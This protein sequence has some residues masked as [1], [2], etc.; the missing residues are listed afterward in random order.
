MSP[1]RSSMI[2]PDEIKPSVLDFPTQPETSF[3]AQRQPFPSKKADRDFLG[4]WTAEGSDVYARVS[5]LKNSEHAARSYPT[6]P[7]ML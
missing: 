5:H 3:R 1:H 2:S 4:R 6:D 7:L